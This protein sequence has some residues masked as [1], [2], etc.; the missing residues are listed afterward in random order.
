M[1]LPIITQKAKNV[2]MFLQILVDDDIYHN[3]IFLW[4]YFN[5]MHIAMKQLNF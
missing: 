5:V 3:I 2:T 1:H 4:K